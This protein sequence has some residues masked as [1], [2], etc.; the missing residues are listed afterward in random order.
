MQIEDVQEQ[1]FNLIRGWQ[2]SELSQKLYCE[3]HGIR[4]HVFHYW[5]KV[6]RDER[7]VAPNHN[8]TFVPLRIE[9][10]PVARPVFELI[11]PDGKRLVFHQ[12]PSADF[13]KALL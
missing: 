3:Q 5:Y 13:I 9:A 10:Q 8:S 11:L 6:Y 7:V 12:Q 1:M 4:Y 2:Q